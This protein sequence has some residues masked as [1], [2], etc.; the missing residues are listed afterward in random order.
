MH[1]SILVLILMMNL[2][3]LILMENLFSFDTNDEPFYT[4][5]SCQHTTPANNFNYWPEIITSYY[6]R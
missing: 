5:K 3:V 4:L 1:D 2:L 6:L